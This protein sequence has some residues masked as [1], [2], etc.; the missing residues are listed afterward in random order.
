ML[1]S[2]FEKIHNYED[3]FN[4][5]EILTDYANKFLSVYYVD[6]QNIFLTAIVCSEYSEYGN[7]SCSKCNIKISDL[8]KNRQNNN[9]YYMEIKQISILNKETRSDLTRL[10]LPLDHYCKTGIYRGLNNEYLVLPHNKYRI[11]NLFIR[12][13]ISLI[14]WFRRSMIYLPYE[15]TFI[16]TSYL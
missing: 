15:I 12:K 10:L 5:S 7:L 3:F 1:K 14:K 11:N 4:D 9:R 16:I 6:E 2:S 13:Q 8:Y